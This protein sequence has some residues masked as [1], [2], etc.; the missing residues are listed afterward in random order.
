MDEE[1]KKMEKIDDEVDLMDLIYPLLKNK[2]FI[3]KGTLYAFILALILVSLFPKTYKSTAKIIVSQN[4]TSVSQQ[5]LSQLT[6][7]SNMSGENNISG[8]LAGMTLSLPVIKFTP[9]LYS[10][11]LD[12]NSVIDYVIEKNNLS[13]LYKSDNYKDLREKIKD[14]ISKDI[15][16]KSDILTV[17]YVD[18]DPSLSY[19][20]VV[21]LIEGLKKVTNQ[22]K[23]TNALERE[24]FY[25]EQLKITGDNIASDREKIRTFQKNL[26]PVKSNENYSVTDVNSL[27][28]R[29][30]LN[31][32]LYNVLLRQ[33][34]AA[35]M[36]EVYNS[37]IIQIVNEPEIPDKAFKPK[38]G[39]IVLVF[40]I[41]VFFILILW[42]LIKGFFSNLKS[43]D[44]KYY[45]KVE[46]MKKFLTFGDVSDSIRSDINKMLRFF[47]LKKS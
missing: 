5:I 34:E 35:K 12:G 16:K 47:R 1:I 30:K 14:N 33:Y 25:E 28:Q 9:E 46:D 40:T 22:M 42:V 39:S 31:E 26:S 3:I 13:K 10:D 23:I 36:D 21:S 4:Q 17:S 43:T 41:T 24:K 6:A 18:R 32:S 44:E 29:I 27:N 11:L 2:S 8:S 19:N 37:S 15:D 45:K 20:V 7:I 38:K